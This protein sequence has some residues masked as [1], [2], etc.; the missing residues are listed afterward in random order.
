M[1]GTDAALMTRGGADIVNAADEP[2]AGNLVS[3]HLLET[4]SGIGREYIDFYFLRIRTAL[5]EF[6]LNGALEALEAAR[7]EGLVRYFGLAAEG[8]GFAVL[9]SWQFRD[10]FEVLLVPDRTEDEASY[11]TLVP[12]ARER[13]V[14]VV[15]RFAQMPGPEA[16][17]TDPMLVTVRTGEDLAA[18]RSLLALAQARDTEATT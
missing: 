6:Q 18:T 7:D 2:G 10:A 17:G 15:R 16:L 3:A 13:R 1:R 14:G 4:L 5:E 12:L 8:S 9:G 11:S